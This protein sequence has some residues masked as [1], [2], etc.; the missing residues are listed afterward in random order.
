MVIIFELEFDKRVLVKPPS[1]MTYITLC[2]F[3][4]KRLDTTIDCKV[5]Y[6]EFLGFSS[7]LNECNSSSLSLK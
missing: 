5:F 4:A 7:D 3:P 1:I 2:Y 6:E